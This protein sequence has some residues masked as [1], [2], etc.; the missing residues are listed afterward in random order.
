MAFDTAERRLRNHEFATLSELESYL[1]R[2]VQNCK[3]YYPRESTMYKDAERI[4]KITTTWMQQN[5]PAYH[6]S[7]I[8]YAPYPTV[9]TEELVASHPP[10]PIRDADADGDNDVVMGSQSS[11]RFTSATP[12]PDGSQPKKRSPLFRNA[13]TEEAARQRRANSTP[14]PQGGGYNG[15]NFQQA[16]EKILDEMMHQKEDESDEIPK[17]D[18]FARLPDRKMFKDYYAVIPHPVSFATLKR[19]IK[20][21]NTGVSKFTTWDELEEEVS[22]IW[23]NARHYNEDGSFVS[24]LADDFEV[25]FNKHLRRAR[26]DVPEP[27]PAQKQKIKLKINAGQAAEPA[28]T[29]KPSLR[30]VIKDSPADSP[31]LTPLS[32]NTSASN[33]LPPRRASTITRQIPQAVAPLAPSAKENSRRAHSVSNPDD[34][35]GTNIVE[36]PL[37]PE[38][39]PSPSLPP[40]TTMQQQ[41]QQGASTP[42]SQMN[43]NAMAPPPGGRQAT[44]MNEIV[45]QAAAPTPTQATPA[46]AQPPTP[47]QPAA[48]PIAWDAVYRMEGKST[49][50]R[51]IRKTNKLTL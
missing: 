5:N 10:P 32:S 43:G 4:R 25:F 49:F 13:Q 16:Q 27:Q 2:M 8:S 18:I 35:T 31:A 15:L 1:K 42:P 48:P 11:S 47:P 33:T 24:E 29:P 19:A 46:Q 22:L 6:D 20:G 7:K 45:P 40:P 14:A 51:L 3:D 30:M 12:N 21:G 34:D 41:Q 26:K 39:N 44:P 23:K 28:P 38:P 37:K 50:T 36:E 17:Y 9:I